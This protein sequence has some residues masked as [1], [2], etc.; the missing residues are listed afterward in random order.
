MSGV[1]REATL[2]LTPSG[3]T[4]CLLQSPDL[5]NACT[6]DAQMKTTSVHGDRSLIA[7]IHSPSE[8]LALPPAPSLEKTQQNN[9]DE[10]NPEHST[11]LDSYEGTISNQDA[12][13]HPLAYPGMQQPLNYSD[14][15]SLR[16]KQASHNA[17]VGNSSLGL[18]EFETLQS[19]MESSV[20]FADMTTLVADSHLPQL[21][22]SITGLDQ[23]EDLTTSQTKDSTDIR[24]DQARACESTF[25]GLSEPGIKNDQKVSDVL[26]GAPQARTQHEDMLKEDD[27]GATEGAIDYMANNVDRKSQIFEPKRP[28]VAWAQGQNKAKKTRENNSKKTEELKPSNHR[29]KA[30]EKPTIPKTKR[31]RNPPELSHDSFKKPRTHLGRHMLESVQ[32]FHPLGKKRGKETGISSSQALLNFSSNKD[33]RTGPTKTSLGDVPREGRG[34]GKTPGNA[35]RTESSAHKECPPPSQDELP[36]PG[37]VKLVPLP[38]LAMDKPQ[39][40]PVS[41]KLHCLASHR[42][43]TA[44]P[45]RSHSHSARQLKLKPS[46]PA[47]ASASLMASDKSTLPIDTSATRPI[48]SKPIQSCTGPQPTASLHA[49]YRGSSHT[50]LHREPLSFATN[51]KLDPSQPQIQYLLRDFSHQPIPWRKV[52]IPGP[53]ISQSITEKQKPE[54][55]A[56]KRWA[57]QERENAAKCTSLGKP[58]LFLQREKDMEISRYYGYAV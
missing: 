43:T 23:M 17:T 47:P 34:P 46:Q 54:R 21:L 7:L 56:M 36:L 33:P 19:V 41:T 57:Q 3:Q 42:P 25:S 58:P 51:K 55:E 38:F 12:S 20:D 8:F 18:E 48:R 26:H 16:Q 28:R 53:V 29:V 24:R 45:V 15:G 14:T 13:L 9:A 10:M 35:Q 5:G 6:Q 40:R 31:K 22:N 50:S 27:P 44:Y 39:A 32:V 4:L 11:P 37:K 30:E 2:R 49:P 52:D 1:R